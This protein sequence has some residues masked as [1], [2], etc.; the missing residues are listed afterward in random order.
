MMEPPRPALSVVA[1]CYNEQDAL[2]EF[3]RRVGAALD[4]ADGTS[5]IVVVDDGSRDR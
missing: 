4:A 1:P 5:E 2:P 3:L